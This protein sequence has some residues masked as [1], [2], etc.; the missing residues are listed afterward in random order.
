V[1]GRNLSLKPRAA[2]AD[3]L[4][5][6]VLRGLPLIPDRA[7]RLMM[8][9]R[10]ITADGD[11]LDTT[12]QL[13][14]MAQRA[15]G[16]KSFVAQDDI[17]AA[18]SQLDAM[19][20]IFKQDIPV[21]EVTD[22]SIP[23]PA[24]AIPVRHYRTGKQT[25]AAEVAPLLVFYHGGGYV[26]GSL[27]SHDDLCRLI[28]RDGRLH[29]LSVGYRL[30][31]EHKAPAGV[32]DGYAAYRWAVDNAVDLGTDPARV[33]VGGDS[34]GGNL[35]AVAAQLARNERVQPPAVQLL[36]YPGTDYSATTRSRTLFADG[37]LVTKADLAWLEHQYLDGA[38][39]DRTDP[40]VSPLRADDL[41]GLC[42]ALVLTGG[43]DPLR[44]EGA[45]YAKA[46]REAGVVVDHREFGSLGHGWAS[47]FPLGGDS[48]VA[49]TEMI[50]ALRAHLSWSVRAAEK[51]AAT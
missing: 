40:L 51:P 25:A 19:A 15:A 9:G 5:A 30:A 2:I 39:V 46:M 36:M 31:P 12:L 47:F 6:V 44:D 35:A 21:A 24:G 45:Q 3:T 20:A 50:S 8:G 14:W 49:V 41:S 26:N 13:L 4:T 16:N 17:V 33:A 42:P 1:A 48:A 11:T 43:F 18:R 29:V 23:G 37:F 22:F 38:D 28:C 34:A 27:D 32:L 7:K 10:S